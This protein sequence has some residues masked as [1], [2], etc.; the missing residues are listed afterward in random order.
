[1]GTIGSGVMAARSA[2]SNIMKQVLAGIG[3]AIGVVLL[4]PS[5][6]TASGESSGESIA[7]SVLSTFQTGMVT[8]LYNNH[9]IIEIDRRAYKFAPDSV[10]LDIRGRRLEPTDV[11]KEAEVKFQVKKESSDRID[12]MVVFFPR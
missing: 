5:S 8:D 11:V 1:M 9:T 6:H 7:P 10:I 4:I 3:L 12:K 2:N